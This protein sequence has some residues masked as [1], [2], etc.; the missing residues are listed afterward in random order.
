VG[1]VLAGFSAPVLAENVD[2]LR[3]G[4]D[5]LGTSGLVTTTFAEPADDL[6]LRGDG[7]GTDNRDLLRGAFECGY[8]CDAGPP[9][10][11]PYNP[12]FLVDWSLA[13][14]GS[15]VQ[16]NATSRF[17]TSLIPALS[18]SHEGLRS[19]FDLEAEAE[20]LK[21]QDTV[22][23]ISALRLAIAGEYGLDEVTNFATDGDLTI[24][25][26]A[27]NDPGNPAGTATAPRVFDGD[28]SGTITRDV[29]I[30]YIGLR[31]S[32]GRTDYGD[33]TLVN[34]AIVD[35]SFSSNTRYGA[36]LRLSHRLTP[37]I[38]AYADG[39][40]EYRVYD[41]ASPTLL[42]ALDSTDYVLRGGLTAEIGDILEADGSVGIALRKF[43]NTSLADVQAVLYEASL[44]FRPDETLELTGTVGT[45]IGAPGPNGT[46]TASIERV[47]TGEARY[48]VN[49]WWSVW[50]A[51]GWSEKTAVGSPVV[52]TTYNVG[53]GSEYLINT[54]VALTADYTFS[55]RDVTATV[56]VD[57]H[58]ATVGVKVSR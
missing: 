19:T 13:L 37:I 38:A 47:I 51:A 53:G 3:L 14:R 55:H 48:K 23:R 49:T 28:F 4:N 17:E 10:R 43:A 6:Q 32:V 31:G 56:P 21:P 24:T 16:E 30:A 33:T 25:Q 2:D 39:S 42:V 45:N 7:S 58:K 54:H 8:E 12:P 9:P 27:P 22:A 29:G 57:T 50:A 26:A 5:G 1:T 35:N 20:L 15:Y 46:G 44:T 11:E 40:V 52:E 34:G 36:G 41:A 18:L